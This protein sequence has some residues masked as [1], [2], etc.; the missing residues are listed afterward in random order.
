[1]DPLDYS[2]IKVGYNANVVF[3]SLPNVTYTGKV[4]L[5][6]HNW[7]PSRVTR[8]WKVMWCWMPGRPPAC[9]P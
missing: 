4:T 5:I 1:M 3:D 6:S 8:S 7:S 9:R 2:N